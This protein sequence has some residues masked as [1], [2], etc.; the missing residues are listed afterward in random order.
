MKRIVLFTVIF[1]LCNAV[2]GQNGDNPPD[3]GKIKNLYMKGVMALANNNLSDAEKNFNEVVNAAD[4]ADFNIDNFKAKSWYFLGD[5]QFI[6]RNYD[7]AVKYYR[8]V[9][10]KYYTQEIYSKGMYKL[11]RTLVVNNRF[12]EGLEVLKDYLEKYQNQDA[13][14]DNAYF[15]MAKAFIG[16]RDYQP[17]LNAYHLIL[18][19]FPY[20][21]L[22]YEIRNSIDSLEKIIEDQNRQNLKSNSKID[23]SQTIAQKRDKLVREKALLEKMAKLLKIKQRMLEIKSEKVELLNLL[24]Q[25]KDAESKK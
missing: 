9:T 18:E 17:A 19:K 20:S 10:E 13:F 8:V 5:V 12:K 23:E 25:Q 1:I 4:T 3:E 14:A 6:R 21:T 22:A 16:L 7:M 24:K 11:G 2:F 15:W